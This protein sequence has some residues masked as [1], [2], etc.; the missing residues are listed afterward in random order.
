MKSLNRVS[1]AGLRTLSA[2]ASMKSAEVSFLLHEKYI[3]NI[4]KFYARHLRNP[5]GF[6]GRIVTSVMNKQNLPLY[7]A[8]IKLLKP[9][10]SD[11]ILDIGCGNGYVLGMLAK[12]YGGLYIGIDS[13]KSIIKSARRRNREFVETGKITFICQNA[14]SM[15]FNEKSFDKIF[16]INT[17]YF[18]E[19]PE[20]IM[21]QIHRALKPKGLFI[22]TLYSNETLA[23]LSHTNYGYN[24]HTPKQL[25]DF[26]NGADFK[27]E[28]VPILNNAAYCVMYEVT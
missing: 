27:V 11:V 17:V 23:R 20:K 14:E 10:K 6:G 26:G 5:K 25:I 4:K 24:W 16:T 18:W 3:M 2:S 9:S 8:T 15:D 22:N 21:T 13:S 28:V 7:E 1:Q 12:Q 19:E